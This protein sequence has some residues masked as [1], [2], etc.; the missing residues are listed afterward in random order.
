[1]ADPGR[2]VGPPQTLVL[3]GGSTPL[4]KPTGE[5]VNIAIITSESAAYRFWV[6]GTDPI[7]IGHRVNPGQTVIL[8]GDALRTFRAAGAA[9]VLQISYGWIEQ[10]PGVPFAILPA[11][12]SVTASGATLVSI[13]DI[14][15]KP[16]YRVAFD[17]AGVIGVAVDVCGSPT[18]KIKVVRLHF[19]KPAVAQTPLIMRLSQGTYSDGT[20]TTPPGIPLDIG[21]PAAS[22]VVTLFTVAPTALT[23]LG[24]LFD[25]DF[26]TGD[27]L[28]EEFGNKDLES[29]PVILHEVTDHFNLV[30]MADSQI[31]G[32]VEFTEE[33]V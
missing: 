16:T 14:E 15:E 13:E 19:A 7:G 30:L 28:F 20:S 1:M 5:R 6:D 18:K 4:T 31:N 29:R 9:A 17:L 11:G 26:A 25:S 12:A 23:A 8:Y 3:G 32:Y 24:T 27:V 22:A 33:D 21:S 10:V 2:Y